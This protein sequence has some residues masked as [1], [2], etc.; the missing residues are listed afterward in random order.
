MVFTV[1]IGVTLILSVANAV[2]L[3]LVEL[4]N[5]M[6]VTLVAPVPAPVWLVALLQV[7][8]KVPPEV[9][10]AGLR[11]TAACCAPVQLVVEAAV[12]AVVFKAI[13]GAT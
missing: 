11:V 9:P 5:G 2:V 12:G 6:L 1:Y 7:K 8:L 13:L 4:N 10:V 3:E